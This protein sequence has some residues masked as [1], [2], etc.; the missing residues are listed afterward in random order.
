MTGA[1]D[2]G[3]RPGRRRWQ[4]WLRDTRGSLPALELGLLLP[5]L[6]LLLSFALAFGLV[7]MQVMEF[8]NAF[9]A[10]LSVAARHGTADVAAAMSAA[11]GLTTVA[12]DPAPATF[13]ACADSGGLA[14]PGLTAG[15]A[16]P[17]ADHGAQCSALYPANCTTACSSGRLPGTY[18]T[19]SAQYT[20]PPGL[21]RLPGFAGLLTATGTVRIQ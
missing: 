15:S 14:C 18:V 6:L 4:G 13:C 11:G 19:V 3:A 17:I 10:A 1:A 16:S 9:A 2:C 8:D 21:D 20:M 7:L 12:A 5:P